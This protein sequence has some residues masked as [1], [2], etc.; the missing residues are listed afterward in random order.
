MPYH[1]E[2]YSANF[3]PQM[4]DWLVNAGRGKNVEDAVL[5]LAIR[6]QN[7]LWE[8]KPWRNLVKDVT[9]DLSSLSYTFPDDFGRIVDIWGNLDGTGVA[10]YWYYEGDN[11]E[12]GYKLRDSFTKAAGHSWVI[13]FFFEQSADTN[14]RYQAVLPDFTGEGTEYLYFPA[15]LML[16]K[17]QEINTREKGDI[18]EWQMIDKALGEALRRYSNAN[19]W[20]NFDPGPRVNDRYGNEIMPSQYSLNGSGVRS[21]S[22]LPNSYNL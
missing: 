15:N 17:A 1:K 4:L 6:A 8:E 22:P 3:R 10:S 14:M 16:L 2:T 18:K 20:V 13:T 21:Y 9:L 5:S 19:Q 11:Y 7:D 12:R